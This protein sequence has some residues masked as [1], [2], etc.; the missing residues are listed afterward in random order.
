MPFTRDRNV[1][2]FSKLKSG[3]WGISGVNLE[4]GAV[5]TVTKKSGETTDAIVGRILW[6]GADG[7]QLAT[8]A[9]RYTTPPATRATDDGNDY[10]RDEQGQ[11][12]YARQTETITMPVDDDPIP[13]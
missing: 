4:P 10:G 6:T 8:L 3:S 7:T 2:T 11:P 1:I 12:D 5:V 13:F 9:D